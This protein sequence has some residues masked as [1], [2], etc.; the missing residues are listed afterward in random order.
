MSVVVD[1]LEQ[2]RDALFRLSGPKNEITPWQGVRHTP[3]SDR[4][5]AT[6]RDRLMVGGT[7]N[8]VSVTILS[9]SGQVHVRLVLED[10]F[11]TE[12][13]TLC[14]GYIYPGKEIIGVGAVPFRKGDNLRLE[15][16][17]TQAGIVLIPRGQLSL[18]VYISGG[19]HATDV[20]SVDGPGALILNVS[21]GL[22]D[23]DL[24]ITVPTGA[25]ARPIS[26]YAEYTATSTAGTRLIAMNL[27]DSANDIIYEATEQTLTASQTGRAMYAPGI[28]SQVVVGGSG[29]PDSVNSA[30]H[31]SIP[32]WQLPAG[33]NLRVF[34]RA[35]IAEGF[36]DLKLE[37][38]W[39]EWIDSLL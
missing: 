4:T 29:A 12:K 6:T 28:G 20:G 8:G 33:Y 34:D 31:T 26:F 3:N 39:E 37:L 19:W 9:G 23:T 2:I 7:I 25:R 36:D 27:R 38:L 21:E 1:R 16:R 35:G 17:G 30:L 15:S 11:Q 14:R 32:P 22:D 5:V 18:N 10:E 13:M 24:T